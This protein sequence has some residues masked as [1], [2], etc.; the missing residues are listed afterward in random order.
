MTL[1]ELREEC[2]AI[3][4]DTALIDSDRLWP[5]V[6]MNRYINRT[7][8]HIAKETKCI[9]DSVTPAVCFITVAP[10]DYTTVPSTDPDYEW[11]N[12]SESWLYHRNV[13]KNLFDLHSSILA[14]DECKWTTKQWR[15]KKVSVQAWQANPW[16]EQVVG[17]PT[18]FATD[19]T[20]GKL[21]INFRAEDADT[22][23]LI[24]RRMPIVNLVNDSDSPEFRLSYHDMML[25]GILNQMYSKQDAETIDQ[26]KAD[27]Y[28]LAYLKDIDE[29]KQEESLLNERLRVNY[30]LDAFR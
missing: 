6:D 3:T 15:L 18:E 4:R 10:V 22:L 26:A 28:Y 7:Y 11:L 29:I 1:K 2:W 27:R 13:S 21:A 12:S 25:N 19:L 30:S 20:N 8:R 14:I 23:R 5:T 24:V 16:W 9:R 17:M